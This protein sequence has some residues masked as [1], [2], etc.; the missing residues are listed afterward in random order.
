MGQTADRRP[1]NTDSL[2]PA[3]CNGHNLPWGKTSSPRLTLPGGRLP[4][5]PPAPRGE[6][7]QLVE[8]DNRI[9]RKREVGRGTALRGSVTFG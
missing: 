7:A 4:C 8:R 2:A 5:S 1:A 6:L 3:E 9:C